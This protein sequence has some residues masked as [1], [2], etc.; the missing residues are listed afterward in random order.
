MG[1]RKDLLTFPI[2]SVIFVCSCISKADCQNFRNNYRIDVFA[3]LSEY[4]APPKRDQKSLPLFLYFL[5]VMSIQL[6]SQPYMI[7]FQKPEYWGHGHSQCLN[8]ERWHIGV[9]CIFHVHVL[10]TAYQSTQCSLCNGS[11]LTQI[12]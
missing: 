10:C 2:G 5:L 7:F 4:P 11:V 3:S 9:I 1:L 6:E 8:V 12:H